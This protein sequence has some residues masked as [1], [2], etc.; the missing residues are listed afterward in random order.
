M[1]SEADKANEASL[2]R[3]SHGYSLASMPS[4]RGLSIKE[5]VEQPETKSPFKPEGLTSSVY[6]TSNPPMGWYDVGLLIPHEAI[7]GE[8]EAM[9]KSVLAMKEDYNEAKDWWRVLYFAQWYIEVFSIVIHSHHENEEEIYFPWIAAKA[10]VPE[11]LTIDHKGLVNLLA[12]IESVCKE[13]DKKTGKGCQEEVK[14]LKELVPGFIDEMNTHLEEEETNIPA[15]LRD[16]FTQEE[17]HETVQKILE[18][19]GLHGFQ[20]FV[21]SI[22]MHMRKWATDGFV[23]EFIGSMPPPLQVQLQ[24]EF[25]PDYETCVHPK[26]D[27]PLLDSKPA[28]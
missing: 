22:V 1:T 8:C 28:L 26:R 19:E 13:V 5:E 23:D 15:L 27:A 16:N 7:R 18:K 25:I 14:K 4:M 2:R 11:K 6:N 21:P 3:R 20:F 24:N 17:E 12:Q 9:K 10:K